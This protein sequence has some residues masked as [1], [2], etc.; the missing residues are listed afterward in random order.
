MRGRMEI[1]MKYKISYDYI[2]KHSRII[3][4]IISVL[5]LSAYLSLVFGKSIWVDEAYTYAL[6]EHSYADICKI[7]AADVHPPLYYILLKV[8]SMLFHDKMLAGKLFSA[9]SLWIAGVIGGIEIKKIFDAKTSLIFLL[10]FFSF[11]ALLA[12]S[13]E[14]RMYSL[15]LLFVLINSIYGYRCYTKNTALNWTIFTI[16]GACAA[17]THYFALVSVG[18]VYG[19]LLVGLCVS[20][21]K[22]LKYYMISCAAL[23]LLYTPWIKSFAEQ[24]AVKINNEYWIPPIT[25]KTI[26]GYLSSLFYVPKLRGYS[27]IIFIVYLLILI[28]MIRQ[29]NKRNTILSICAIAVPVLTIGAGVAASLIVRPVFVIRYAIPAMSVFLIFA[30]LGIAQ[31]HAKQAVAVFMLIFFGTGINYATTLKG[32]YMIPDTVIN[33]SFIEAHSDCEAYVV[34]FDTS[35]RITHVR[36]VLSFWDDSKPIYS[37][38]KI[39]KASPY[40]NINTMEDFEAAQINRF[41]LFIPEGEAIPERYSEYAVVDKAAVTIPNSIKADTYILEKT[42]LQ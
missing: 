41:L 37:K 28:N 13:T 35:N 42:D 9:L 33:S 25:L 4:W 21:R 1:K 34:D 17:Y 30:A 16:S 23:I 15:A 7:T 38:C 22:S 11:P 39:S 6:I 19:M 26:K 5:A 2:E 8:F 32:E 20:S 27:A 14:V 36:G 29:G 24:L 10:A 40:K 12:Y 31:L 18:I 3:F